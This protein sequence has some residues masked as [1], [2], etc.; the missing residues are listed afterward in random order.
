MISLYL[1]VFTM[2]FNMS[3]NSTKNLFTQEHFTIIEIDAPVVDSGFGTPV[4]SGTPSTGMKTYKFNDYAGIIP[5]DGVR[6]CILSISETPTKLQPQ[7]GLA[8]RASGSIT[9]ADFVGDPNPY[10]PSVTPEMRKQ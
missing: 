8:V 1:L 7:K 9:M 3:F 10:A 4:S 6:K 5:E 2:V